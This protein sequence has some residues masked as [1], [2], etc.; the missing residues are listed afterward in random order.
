MD[1]TETTRRFAPMPVTDEQQEALDRLQTAAINYT[2]ALLE[3]C[4]P[5]WERALAE[6][7]A[8]QAAMW[9]TKA[10]THAAPATPRAPGAWREEMT[11]M[12]T[13]RD[14]QLGTLVVSTAQNGGCMANRGGFAEDLSPAGMVEARRIWD[15]HPEKR[16]LFAE[17]PPRSWATLPANDPGPSPDLDIPPPETDPRF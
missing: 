8:E 15:E 5:G 7:N 12:T 11:T 2:K 3:H 10:V 1:D 4:P 9:A 14:E 17:E 13:F 16:E 6:T